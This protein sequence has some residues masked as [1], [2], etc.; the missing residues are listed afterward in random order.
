[1]NL[2]W[3]ADSV[4]SYCSM[5]WRHSSGQDSFSCRKRAK[6]FQQTNRTVY[7]MAWLLVLTFWWRWRKSL[8]WSTSINSGILA[9]E[10]DLVVTL[11]PVESVRHI[12]QKLF[13]MAKTSLLL[14][15]FGNI[16]T[17]G[18]LLNELFELLFVQLAVIVHVAALEIEFKLLKSHYQEFSSF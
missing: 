1:M 15:N 3:L 2:C 9:L 18:Q 17:H 14:E 12:P 11:K 4:G 6:I 10:L 8:N 13:Q 5:S 7:K 16:V